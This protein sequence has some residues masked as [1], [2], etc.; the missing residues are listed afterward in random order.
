[1][2][3]SVNIL[4]EQEKQMTDGMQKRVVE[5]DGKQLEFLQMTS[6]DEGLTL[7]SVACALGLTDY[8]WLLNT[9]KK[10]RNKFERTNNWEAYNLKDRE[11]SDELTNK[12]T[13]IL[14][15]EAII[16]L[17]LMTNSHKKVELANLV[18]ELMDIKNQN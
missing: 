4:Y 16:I 7:N 9:F 3:L 2:G 1:M 6:V 11:Y 10:N 13:P 8:N 14:Y 18:I 12:C 15:R 5:F 17:A